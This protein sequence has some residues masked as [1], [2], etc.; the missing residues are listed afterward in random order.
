M[1]VAE[2]NLAIEP[3]WPWSIPTLGLSTMIG[4]ALLLTGLTLWT[5]L[6][7]RRTHWFRLCM[8]LSLR[9]FALLLAFCMLLRPSFGVTHLEGVET[10]K[11]VVVF[12]ASASMT[13]ADGA[14][15]ETRWKQVADLWASRKVQRRLEQLAAEQ[16]IEVVK[17]LAAE[18]LRPDEPNA[19]PTG[20]STEIGVWLQQ[21]SRKHGHEK[22]RG[23]ALFSDGGDNGRVSPLEEA[24]KWRG[25]SPIHTFGVGDPKNAKFG[26]DIALTHLN[27]LPSL[28]FVKSKIDVK[29]I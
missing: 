24:R 14:Q 25:V 12:D 22:L 6:G 2:V 26:K 5:Y 8:V 21:L 29:V 23:V 28:V 20:K 4:I 15:K 16:K 19:A 13:V 7:T 3:P 9:L 1:I 17:Y 11:L 18:E 27:E 10:S